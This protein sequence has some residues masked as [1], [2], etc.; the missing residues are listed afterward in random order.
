M[1]CTYRNI[2][3]SK[4]NWSQREFCEITLIAQHT[5]S[6]FASYFSVIKC[7]T[8]GQSLVNSLPRGTTMGDGFPAPP[9]LVGGRSVGGFFFYIESYRESWETIKQWSASY[10]NNILKDKNKTVSSQLKI[11][12]NFSKRN[13]INGKYAIYLLVV[14]KDGKTPQFAAKLS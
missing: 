1:P 9:S 13:Q 3:I 6:M 12:H 5:S 2:M 14:Q 7:S 11:L 4:W 10:L 8:Q